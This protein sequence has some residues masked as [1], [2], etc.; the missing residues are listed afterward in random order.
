MDWN[1]LVQI[2]ILGCLV[3]IIQFL[4]A[5][6]VVNTRY[7]ESLYTRLDEIKDKD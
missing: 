3:F 4:R 1:L 7:W 5:F 6:D 2:G